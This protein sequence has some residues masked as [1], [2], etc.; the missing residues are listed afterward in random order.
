VKRTQRICGPYM[1]HKPTTCTDCRNRNR[2]AAPKGR[3]SAHKHHLSGTVVCVTALRFLQNCVIRRPLYR[4]PHG[5]TKLL[6]SSALTSRTIF[7]LSA[8]SLSPSADLQPSAD[9][10]IP[11]LSCGIHLFRLPIRRRPLARHRPNMRA[12][13]RR[14]LFY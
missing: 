13:I 2:F 4:Y 5:Q 12:P 3:L 11:V 14:I 1:P 7:P 8:Q 10:M 9:D 6:A